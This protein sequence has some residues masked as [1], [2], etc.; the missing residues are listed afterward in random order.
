MVRRVPSP[1]EGL[2]FAGPVAIAALVR[3]GEAHPREIVELALR[4]IE[5]LNP[6]L[7]AFRTVMAEEALAAADQVGRDGPLA[8]VP[9]AVK[10]DTPVAG[11]VTTRGSKTYGSAAPEDAEVVRRIRAA[12]AILIGITNVPELMIWPWT[13][14]DATGITRNPWDPSRSPGGSSGGSAA[15]VAAG[16]VPCAT[17][18]DG[19][20]SIRIPAACC[21]LVGMKPS[22]GR[23]SAMPEGEHWLGLSTR[24]G[25]ARTVKDSALMLEVMQGTIEGDTDRISGSADGYLEAAGT[26]PGRLRIA[27]TAKAPAGLLVRPSEDQRR[28]WEHT[29]ALLEQL[30]HH[31]V[32]HDP[33]W[34]AVGPQFSQTW[35]RGIYE[36]SLEVPDRS[37]LE[38]TTR[39]VAALGRLVSA[40]RARKLRGEL[41]ARTTARILALW[42]DFDVLVTPGLARTA[43]PAEGAYGRGTLTA[44]NLASRFTPWTPPFNLTGQPAVTLPAGFGADGLP[45]SVQLVGR[46]EA[47]RTLY[48]LAAQIEEARPWAEDK[49]ALAVETPGA[50]TFA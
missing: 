33:S 41:R 40:G 38:P 32:E 43:L 50:S 42:D 24:G 30:G 3:S 47:E 16:M 39:R 45:L 8:G 46:P 10:G 23:V 26:P 2:A 14:S 1:D 25:L 4:R 35:L 7:N 5:D 28:A 11:Q 12:G 6:R 21:G 44:I 27:M 18:A 13:A 22:R 36:D 31:V 9:V 15:A 49:P 17:A 34:G 29:G 19:G 37:Q 20:G 48:A